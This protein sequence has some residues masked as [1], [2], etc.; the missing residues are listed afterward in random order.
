MLLLWSKVRFKL[1][2]SNSLCF[3]QVFH[4]HFYWTKSSDDMY[5]L[6]EA[7]GEAEWRGLTGHPM[8]KLWLT[9]V[10]F[11]KARWGIVQSAFL[12]SSLYTTNITYST[13]ASKPLAY[14]YLLTLHISEVICCC[15]VVLHIWYLFFVYCSKHWFIL[16]FLKFKS[17]T[18]SRIF[19]YKRWVL[20]LKDQMFTH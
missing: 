8:I 14:S 4:F 2:Y 5:G 20:K 6:N 11:C 10:V 15:F 1:V 16:K 19:S 13:W 9:F 18:S 7:S 12:N 17:I 3:T